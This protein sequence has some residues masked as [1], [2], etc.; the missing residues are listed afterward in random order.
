[1][2][3]G[4]N[5]I[6][7][8]LSDI[9]GAVQGAND[10]DKLNARIA[11]SIGRSYA[12]AVRSFGTELTNVGKL[13]KIQIDGKDADKQLRQLQTILQTTD[14]TFQKFTE[15][16]TFINGILWKTSG[17]MKDVTKE[18]T[19][20]NVAIEKQAKSLTSLT[21]QTSRLATNLSSVGD[22]NSKLAPQLKGF[23]TVT[24]VVSSNLK[25]SGANFQKYEAILK[26]ANGTQLKLNETISR[27]PDGMQKV[28]TT[29]EPVSAAFLKLQ[30]AQAGV[31]VATT[32]LTA[33]LGRLGTDFKSLASINANFANELSSVGNVVR[34]IRPT[35]NEVSGD[36]KTSGISAETSSG[37]YV[38]LTEKLKNTGGNFTLLN[39]KMRETTQ[40][41]A[42]GNNVFANFA[43]SVKQLGA[44][45]LLTIPIWFALR[46]AITGV[47]QGISGGI[48]DLLAFDLALQ[49]I[50]NNLQ[51][52][53]AEVA[54]AFSKIRSSITEASKETGISTEIIAKAVKEFATLGFSA[55]E[56]LQGALGATKLSIALFGDAGET[57]GAFAR[58]LNIMIDRSK[59]AKYAV[60]QM[61][62]AF[63]L[64]SQLE[65]T[66]N[67]EIKN[68]TEALDKFAGTAAGVGL[69]MNQTLA[70]L[71]AVGTAGRAGS[72]GAT[73][74][75]TSFN[76]L[77][78]N[79][80]KI[81]K[82]L[83]LVVT[84]GESTFTTFTKILNTIAELNKTPGGQ[85]AAI[86]AISDIFG[87]ARG[88]KVVQSL[89]AVKDI[90]D[91]NIATLPS[92][93]ALNV[94]VDRTMESESKQAEILSNRIKEMGKS[95][96]TAL[97]GSEDFTGAIVTLNN[98]VKGLTE[99]LKPLGS[100]IHAIFDNLG[101][102]AGG[103]F[104]LNWQKI[105]AIRAI[106][107]PLLASQA[108]LVGAGETL[109]I[110]FSYG[111]LGGF[112]LL[113]KYLVAGVM[114]GFAGIGAAG[115]GGILAA[116]IAAIFSPIT[117]T[118]GIIG[119]LTADVF[120]EN[121]IK[122]IEA[123]NKKA[124]S[125]F[126]KLIDGLKGNL[127][128]ADLSAL[129]EKMT[130]K[131][132][133]GDLITAREIGALR[134]RLA[135]QIEKS[136]FDAKPKVDVEPL[137]S[138]ADTQSIS[139]L[140]LDRKLD[141]L[142]LQ[143]AT[144]VQLAQAKILGTDA[145]KIKEDTLSLLSNQ[146]DLEKAIHEEKRLQ[147]KLGSDSIK[148]FEIA[149][150]SGVEVA[151]TIGDVLAGNLN[152]DEFISQGGKAVT[153]FMQQFPELFKQQQAMAFYQGKTIPT[154]T[155]EQT[156]NENAFQAAR[157]AM[158]SAFDTSKTTN[159]LTGGQNIAIQEEALR[160]RTP[161]SSTSLKLAQY[162]A[163]EQFARITKVQTT[164]PVTINTTIDISKLA[165][166]KKAVIDEVVRQ[167]PIVGTQVNDMLIKAF[168]G[169]QGYSL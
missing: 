90:L 12:T 80:P 128:I 107:A 32:Q 103:A 95:F 96:F 56:S 44:R 159:I 58:A 111:F 108:A 83:G 125:A 169:R 115:A 89:I 37:K 28:K 78:S 46:A 150:T 146:L 53:P 152:F 137:I 57:A 47:F 110:A 88:I 66:N 54:T 65:E 121:L 131:L 51:G 22:I 130:L 61:N 11:S 6:V 35:I 9:R 59:G 157:D 97:A 21:G 76:Q 41:V 154:P 75:S 136:Q 43:N 126:N 70:I 112:K 71:A 129:I 123:K 119:K 105:I 5:Y 143:G 151:K 62:E 23:G 10:L 163:E 87:G 144:N 20:G 156:P 109:S 24:E 17:S 18:F 138:F 15:T 147:N 42:N 106:V 149:Q 25:A 93:A 4:T 84:S 91:K 116:A 30:A 153:V 36:L 135:D 101:F 145:L 98:V 118:V 142:K 16:Q 52:S 77:L 161:L 133:P 72:E 63:A 19:I 64:T 114:A 165:E 139:K 8:Y 2:N 117:I 1:M 79:I 86:Q 26:T 73:L 74:L 34:I 40:E 140:I 99:G 124:Q 67:F 113:G 50:R 3:L 33:P 92:F 94:K 38:M 158:K 162:R 82:S 48:K 132:K 168:Y 164:V 167:G 148:I 27:T 13:Q 31:V 69:T 122:G 120:T 104:L 127:S 166:A 68:V 155:P 7:T 81:S 102:I 45:A 60:D 85:N 49:K 29:I 14:G 100:T 141:E 55:N 134:K 160:N 39:A